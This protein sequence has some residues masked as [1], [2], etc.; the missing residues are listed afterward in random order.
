M[1]N[2]W[3]DIDRGN[4]STWRKTCRSASLTEDKHSVND[5]DG[6]GN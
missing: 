4:G 3:S 6:E 2:R 1:G 5:Y